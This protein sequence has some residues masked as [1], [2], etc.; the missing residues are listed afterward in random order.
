MN[1]EYSKKYYANHDNLDKHLG[2]SIVLLCKKYG[3]KKILDVG[4]GTGQ[5]VSYLR[6]KELA[7]FGC[8]FSSKAV[9]FAKNY[10]HKKYIKCCPATKLKYKRNSFDLLIS[11]SVIEHISYKDALQFLHEAQRVLKKNGIIFLVTPNYNS[12]WRF[13]MGK[14]WFGYSDPTHIYFYSKKSLTNLL[15]SNYFNVQTFT[16]KSAYWCS[17]EHLPRPLPALPKFLKPLASLLLFSTPAAVIRDSLWV[18]ARK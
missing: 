5:L 16:P 8:D 18:V 11:I 9:K 13:I 12:P 17:Q 2:D 4:C 1:K 7:T 3:V 14:A 15:K 10:N 6:S